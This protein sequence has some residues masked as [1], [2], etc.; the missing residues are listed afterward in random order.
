MKILQLIDL[1]CPTGGGSTDILRK[2]A[3]AFTQKGHEV[4]IYTSDY[5][6]DR[7]YIASLEGV[8]VHPFRGWLN[9]LGIFLT[10]GIFP[11]ARKRLKD[12]DIVHMHWHRSFQAIA[13]H[14]YA[15]KYGIPYVVDDHGTPRISLGARGI[16]QLLWWL[17]D[18]AFGYRIL[19]DADKVIAESGVGVDE[20]KDLGVKEDK[21][22][23]IMPPLDVG[24]F[25]RLPPEGLFREKYDIKQKHIVMFLGRLHW[26]KG[27]YF[28]IES[29]YELVK[30]RSDIVL[31]I[32]GN[33]DGQKADLIKLIEKRDLTDKVLFTGFFGG[34]DK[35]SALVDADVLVQ[36]SVYEQGVRV[37]FEAILCG[38]PIIFTRHTGAG[39]ILSRIDAGYPVEYGNNN[40]LRDMIQLVLDNPAEAA[41]KTQKGKDY[42]NNNLS[43]EKGIEKYLE[44]YRELISRRR[45]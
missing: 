34:E 12:F 35:L 41:V 22:A 15:K 38:T 16:K 27:V 21:I 13:I 26:M 30:S 8:K 2:L 6:L 43:L 18:V 19:R 3:Y 36:A 29:F 4:T 23:V 28:L 24:E 39:E 37:P 33:D 17:F 11:E 32:V 20:Y 5:H 31:V 10:L 1:F 9:P 25:S 14:R 40:E 45:E 42:V 7:E 44:L